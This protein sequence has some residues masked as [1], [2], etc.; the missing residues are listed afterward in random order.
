MQTVKIFVAA[1]DGN[2][3]FQPAHVGGR[4]RECVARDQNLDE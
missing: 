3:H 1:R 4:N 2:R